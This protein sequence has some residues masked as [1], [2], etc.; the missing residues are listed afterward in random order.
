MPRGHLAMVINFDGSRDLDAQATSSWF[1]PADPLLPAC[2]QCHTLLSSCPYALYI[3]RPFC[4]H[5]KP[6][7]IYSPFSGYWQTSSKPSTSHHPCLGDVKLPSQ[8][9]GPFALS[10]TSKSH[11]G[12]MALQGTYLGP[13]GVAQELLCR[14][15]TTSVDSLRS[16]ISL[17]PASWLRQ[18]VLPMPL[19]C[20]DCIAHTTVHIRCSRP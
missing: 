13:F 2:H 19:I 12:H 6:L 3:A 18:P 9:V 5:N 16:S 17:P 8:W 15:C 1:C 20:N 10:G 11:H 7:N 14:L 4:C